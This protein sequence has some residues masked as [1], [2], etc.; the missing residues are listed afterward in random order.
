MTALQLA[1]Q[2]K[3]HLSLVDYCRPDNSATMFMND[4]EAIEELVDSVLEAS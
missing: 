3:L 1:A 2:I 4:Y